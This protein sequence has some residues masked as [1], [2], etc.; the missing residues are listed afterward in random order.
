MKDE[1]SLITPRVSRQSSASKSQSTNLTYSLRVFFLH[2]R[3]SNMDEKHGPACAHIVL[4]GPP[5]RIPSLAKTLSQNAKTS[6]S[7]L[8]RTTLRPLFEVHTTTV[9]E[10]RLFHKTRD[11]Q[12]PR[13]NIHEPKTASISCEIYENFCGYRVLL[14]GREVWVERCSYTFSES[15]PVSSEWIAL[16]NHVTTASRLCRQSPIKIQ[17]PEVSKCYCYIAR[18]F[19]EK[20]PRSRFGLVL[21]AFPPFSLGR[22]ALVKRLR[23]FE[24]IL[25]FPL[26]AILGYLVLQWFTVWIHHNSQIKSLGKYLV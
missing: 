10:L 25:Q 11:F 6:R 24:C 22:K 2:L 13:R 19:S 12:R 3:Y 26:Q 1:H 23:A 5:A 20:L 18:N 15:V 16:E 14:N 4:T 9:L 17:R 7:S 8:F 21:K